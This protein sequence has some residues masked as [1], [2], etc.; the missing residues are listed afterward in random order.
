MM[1]QR[2]KPTSVD[3]A[4]A[5]GVSQSTVSRALG[6]VGGIS[7]ETRA[8][9]VAA[10]RA[11]NYTLD[12]RAARFRT[13]ATRTL[14]VV[15]LTMPRQHAAD[16]NPFY[17]ELLGSIGSA[18]AERGYDLL[19]SFQG[20]EDTLRAGFEASG[21]ADGTIVVGSA[22]NAAGWAF[23]AAAQAAGEHI[24]CWGA[25]SDVLPT[26]R[27][28]NRA[29]AAAAVA[30]LVARGR[31]R[32][33]FL[34]PGWQGQRSY[35]ERRA[36]YA[37]ALASAGLPAIEIAEATGEDREAQGYGA[38]RALLDSG[39]AFDAI[40]AASDLLAFGAM[41]ALRESGRSIPEDIAV[42]G[43]DGIAATAHVSPPLTTIAQDCRVAGAALVDAVLE[44]IAGEPPACAIV[45][46]RLVARA[47]S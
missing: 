10:A 12:H 9:V 37:A 7:D 30:H 5:A 31:S 2:S 16:I 47:S 23:F 46:M 13:G 43:F 11:L 39:A 28:D 1:N 44:A 6:G 19:V 21:R 25:P 14:A 22:R 38:T 20:G 15:I 3:V 42:I 29:A 32:I 18:A 27:C 41:R 36:G 45:P 17:L 8:R 40:F 33:A 4:M 26:V 34:A 24:V 35:A